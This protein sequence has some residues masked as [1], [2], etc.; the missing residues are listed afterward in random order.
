M[1]YFWKT[2]WRGFVV[3]IPFL[4]TFVIAFWLLATLE[5]LMGGVLKHILPAY[6]PGMGILCSILLL[7]LI[8]RFM[9]K[10]RPGSKLIQFG[11]RQMERTPFVKTLYSGVRDV[12]RSI[13]M[14]GQREQ[15]A[16]QVVL[17][18]LG[19]NVQLLG[20]ITAEEV[21]SVNAACEDDTV[22]AVY[23]PF[24]Y[25]LG[26]F[27]VYLPRRL[28]HSVDIPVGQAMEIVLSAAMVRGENVE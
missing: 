22:V 12:I 25:Q 10:G 23:L 21:P 17:V 1:K 20:F 9:D 26:G 27:T 2:V 7:Y 18:T 13:S 4:V 15:N 5:H 14:A 19:N 16:K 11:G 28:L 8:G 24:S 3:I 6:I